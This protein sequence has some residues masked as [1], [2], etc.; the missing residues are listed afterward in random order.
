MALFFNTLYLS[1]SKKEATKCFYPGFTGRLWYPLFTISPKS[2]TG[3]QSHFNR[4][5]VVLPFIGQ[6]WQ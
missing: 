3:Q 2:G 5:I 6:S 1:K 4:L